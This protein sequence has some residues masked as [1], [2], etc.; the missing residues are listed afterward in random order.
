MKA[1]AAPDAGLR[2]I[3]ALLARNAATLG[4]RPAYREK[5]FGIWQCWTWSQAQEEIR[6]LAMGFWRWV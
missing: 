1:V 5:E 6:A 4:N 3:P 2:S